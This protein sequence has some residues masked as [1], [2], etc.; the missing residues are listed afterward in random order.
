MIPKRY[1]NKKSGRM[2]W[3]YI[4]DSQGR[5]RPQVIKK[6]FQPDIHRPND[7]FGLLNHLFPNKIIPTFTMDIFNNPAKSKELD[8][9]IAENIKFAWQLWGAPGD[10]G[11]TKF[12]PLYYFENDVD[13]LLFKFKWG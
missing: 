7:L 4:W 9:W 3:S 2:K 12:K 13:A 8:D 5:I 6:G 10:S 1:R 11:D